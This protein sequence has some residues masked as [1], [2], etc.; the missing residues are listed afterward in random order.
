MF[1][2]GLRTPGRTDP[3]SGSVFLKKFC[4]KIFV[5]FSD[6]QENLFYR[7]SLA[8]SNINIELCSFQYGVSAL[9]GPKVGTHSIVSEYNTTI[10]THSKEYPGYHT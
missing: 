9:T 7:A 1:A 5:M 8:N 6:S 3:I 4:R 2:I 10:M